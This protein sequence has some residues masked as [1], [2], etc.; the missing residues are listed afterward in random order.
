MNEQGNPERLKINLNKSSSMALDE[1]VVLLQIIG[2]ILSFFL[3]RYLIIYLPGSKKEKRTVL[4]VVLVF[5]L[6]NYFEPFVTEL[7]KLLI[8]DP[9]SGLAIDFFKLFLW[10]F[11]ITLIFLIVLAFNA[12]LVRVFDLKESRERDVEQ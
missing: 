7:N 2:I 8:S 11:A 9:S 12:V 4:L 1:I 6:A 10:L 5:V 3:M